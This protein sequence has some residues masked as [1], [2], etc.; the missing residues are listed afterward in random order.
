M[1]VDLFWAKVK[2]SSGCWLWQGAIGANGYGK[3][4]TKVPAPRTIAAHR[5]SFEP[6]TGKDPGV[7]CVLHRCDVRRCVNPR[8]LFLGTRHDNMRDMRQKGRGTSG[9]THPNAKLSDSEVRM[10]RRLYLSGQMSN[11]E[12][13]MHYRIAQSQVSRLVHRLRRQSAEKGKQAELD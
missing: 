13:S 11:K 10:L 9:A 2:K 1:R 3:I 7:L 5:L 8:H 4:S 12:L 6:A